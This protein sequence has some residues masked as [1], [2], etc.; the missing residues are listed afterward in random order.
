MK[1]KFDALFD[2]F[3]TH[4]LSICHINVNFPESQLTN[5]FQEL[6]AY[7]LDASKKEGIDLAVKTSSE[8]SSC[9]GEPFGELPDF[10]IFWDKD[11][12]LAKNLEGAGLRLFNSAEGI[13]VCDD[14][15][16]TALSLQGK[17]PMPK[18]V[19]APKTFDG[20]GYTDLSFLRTAVE[21]VG[22]PM[23]VKEAFGSFGKQVY[24]AGSR[25]EL[26]SIVAGMGAKPFLMQE[27][28]SSSKGRDLRINV[29][30][31]KVLC[32]MLRENENDFRSNISGGGT[33][34]AYTPTKEQEMVALRACEALGL[35]FAGVDVLFGKDGQPLLCEVNSNPHFKSTLDYTG[36][37]VA[38]EIIR[39]I[40]GA[41]CAVG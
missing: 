40:K 14:K 9:L 10:V 1:L 17:V 34:R 28:I 4:R 3:S 37:D 26:Y 22:F 11:Y 25:E 33:G 12:Y 2:F 5:K 31:G 23:V 7:L 41:L 15:I 21:K 8:L 35:D 16:L 6:Y 19:F 29:V 36:V 39:Y 30:G 13:R 24:L 18:T 32:A 20:V 38:L 27:F